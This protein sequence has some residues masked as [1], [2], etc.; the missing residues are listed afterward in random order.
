MLLLSIA[1]IGC[2]ESPGPAP[3]ENAA[4][5]PAEEAPQ[6]RAP[7]QNGRLRPQEDASTSIVDPKSAQAARQVVDRYARLLEQG[8]LAETRVLWTEGSAL[9][10]IE[11]QLEKFERLQAEAGDPGRI[12]GA[13]GSIYVDVPLRLTG[14]GKDGSPIT[15]AGPVTLR[16]ANDV[17]GSTEEQRRWQIYRVDLQPRL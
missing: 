9:G 7:A 5:M 15:L 12:E 6:A 3:S 17:P 10:D 2:R 11:A 16:R 14:Q 4:N 1:L 13:A 8:R